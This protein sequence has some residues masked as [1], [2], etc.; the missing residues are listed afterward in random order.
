MLRRLVREGSVS[1]VEKLLRTKTGDRIPVLLSGA[2]M[3]NDRN[4][5]RGIVCLALD[6]TERKQA[7][8]LRQEA[9]ERLQKIASRVPGLVYQYRLRSDGSACLPFASEAIREIFRVS[10]EEVHE[11]AS[12]LFANL[13]P[14]DYDG[15][16][17][18]IQKSARELTPWQHEF[19]VKFDDGTIRSLFGNAVSQREEDG[20]VLWHGFITDITDRK[21]TEAALRKNEVML[22]CILNSLPLSIFWKNHEGVYLGCNEGFARGANRCPTDVVGKTDFDLPWSRED[23][24]AYRADDR[25]VMALGRAKIHIIE[26]QH[27]ADGTYIWLDT[28]K[29]PLLDAEGRVYGVVGIYDDITERKRMEDELHKAKD[30]AD[31]ANRANSA[32]LANMSH[33]I[34]TPMTAILGYADLMLSENVGRT[35]RE[36]VAVIKRNGEHLL[37][38]IGDILDLS[39]IEAEKLQI[40]PTRCSPVQ[41]VAEVASLMRTQA[42]A[43]QLNLKTELAQPLPETVLTDPLRLRQVLVNLVGNAIKFTDQGEVRIAVRLTSDSGR[44]RLC[45]DVTDTG[46]G[47]SEEQVGKLFKP[48]SQVDNS[49]TRKFGGTGLGLCISKHLAEA[50]GGSIEVRSE[51]GKGSTFSVMIDPG[52]LDGTHMIQN[53]QEALLDRLPSATAATPDKIVLHGRILLAEDGLDNQRLIAMLLRNAGAHVT[54]VENGQLAVE[55][56]LAARE[57]GEPFDVIL[58]DMQMPVMDGYEA[59]RQLRKQGYTGP[60]VALTAHAMAEDCQKCLDAGCNDYLPKPFQHRALLKM[61]ARHIAAEKEAKPPMPDDAKP[62][63]ASGRT[64]NDSPD[65]STSE[66]NANTTIPAAFVYSHLAA[67]LDLDELVDLF[68]QNMPDRINVLDTQAKSRDWNQLAETAHQIKGAAGCYG[69]DEITPCAARLEAAAREAQ[70]EEQILSALDELITLCR[71]VRSGK[72]QA[73]ETPVNTA[74]PVH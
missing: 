32:F 30:A 51:P 66:S 55:A 35:T 73:N 36:H 1:N 11:D 34:R 49:S 40:E 19:R 22:S 59:T 41:V 14:D 29:I 31:A 16:F 23:T 33:E 12:K 63:V 43:K 57:A 4:E 28:T 13:H 62:S 17:A 42:A 48:F 68:V 8:A 50:L 74:V 69:F 64:H 58:M 25:E 44:S 38:V 37:N 2:I 24:E 10:P 72:P 65:S 6:I 61:A 52:P 47:M 53:A 70:Q 67:D 21:R 5:I 45:F 56:A 60:I 39:K 15:I 20:S 54:A 9:L 18:S 26:R 7:E 3:R 71:R 46:I 27:R